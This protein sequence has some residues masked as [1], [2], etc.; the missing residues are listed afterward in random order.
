MYVMSSTTFAS[1]PFVVHTGDPKD[2]ITVERFDTPEEDWED[3]LYYLD[4][5]E[6]HPDWYTRKEVE[7]DG[8][9]CWM[10]VFEEP[11]ANEY[12]QV[13][14]GRG[15]PLLVPTGDWVNPQVALAEAV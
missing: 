3:T 4:C 6:G 2:V 15:A 11:T 14:P 7:V 10:Y 5:L 12:F 9:T 8:V 1:I 13:S